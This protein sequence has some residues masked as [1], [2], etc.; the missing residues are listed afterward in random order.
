MA[1]VEI[2]VTNVSVLLNQ[3]SGT[4][5]N[6][7]N[8]TVVDF[9]QSDFDN[10]GEGLLVNTGGGNQVDVNLTEA[11]IKVDGHI[12]MT[13]A[14]HGMEGDFTFEQT[15]NESGGRVIKAAMAG[16]EISFLSGGTSIIEVY[17][18]N[19][20]LV[21]NSTGLAGE[22]EMGIRFVPPP[23]SV[24][25]FGAM[26]SSVNAKPLPPEGIV[27]FWTTIVPRAAFERTTFSMPE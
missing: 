17:D 8:T 15:T 19:G 10:K 20:T 3:G 24:N 12:T 13:I 21:I 25:A 6:V 14:G 18:I 5:D 27:C 16:V 22:L 7:D 4:N 9:K 26:M 2:T 11:L 1:S 23:L